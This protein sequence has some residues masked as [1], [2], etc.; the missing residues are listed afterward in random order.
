MKRKNDKDFLF[1]KVEP[2]SKTQKYPPNY[3]VD[4]PEYSWR[5]ALSFVFATFR[6]VLPHVLMFLLPLILIMLLLYWLFPDSA[7]S[8]GIDTFFDSAYNRF[9]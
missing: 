5:E 8:V 6:A 9:C 1:R 3:P 7:Q 2:D 4:N